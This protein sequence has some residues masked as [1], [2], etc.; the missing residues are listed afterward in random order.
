MHH[1]GE[2]RYTALDSGNFISEEHHNVIRMYV[3][4]APKLTDPSCKLKL[5]LKDPLLS[6]S[7]CTH[8]KY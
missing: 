2:G 5:A 6:G 8:E 3:L 1:S 4:G 7:H